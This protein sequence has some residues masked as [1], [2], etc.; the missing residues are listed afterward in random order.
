MGNSDKIHSAK[1]FTWAKEGKGDSSSKLPESNGLT[2]LAA[3]DSG[4]GID[5]AEKGN[6]N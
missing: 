6:E 3:G 4:V 5:S 1:W 2:W